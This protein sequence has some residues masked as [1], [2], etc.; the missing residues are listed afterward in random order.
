L[1]NEVRDLNQQLDAKERDYQT[2]N[3]MVIDLEGQLATS[4]QII[5]ECKAKVQDLVDLIEA[6]TPENFGE[7][8]LLQQLQIFEREVEGSI[9][10]VREDDMENMENLVG[11]SRRISINLPSKAKSPK[12]V[13][14]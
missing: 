4:V 2:A 7:F 6:T 13:V 1:Q 5:E 8:S 3:A 14:L 12:K 9:L 11:A 10:P